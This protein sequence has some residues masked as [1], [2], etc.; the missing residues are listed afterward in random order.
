M[1]VQQSESALYHLK[2]IGE[3]RH[4][5]SSAGFGHLQTLFFPQCIYPSGWW[6]ATIAGKTGLSQFRELDAAEKPFDTNYYNVDIH[7][8]AL[9]QP[10]FFKRAFG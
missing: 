5:M 2:L 8:A 1:V 3:M 9:A 7:R 4:A 6:S 10:E